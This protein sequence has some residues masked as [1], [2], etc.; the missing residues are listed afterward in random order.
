MLDVISIKATVT[1]KDIEL[2]ISI[3]KMQKSRTNVNFPTGFED[4]SK[5]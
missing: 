5:L 3:W 1:L 2:I 4:S